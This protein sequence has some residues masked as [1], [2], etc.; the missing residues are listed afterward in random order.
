MLWC[1]LFGPCTDGQSAPQRHPNG[2][3]DYLS[4][5]HQS[6]KDPWHKGHPRIPRKY[7]DTSFNNQSAGAITQRCGTGYYRERTGPH[8]G[9]CV[10]CNC[11]SLS[12][13]CDEQTGRCLNC[14]YNTDGD[15]CER[16]KEGY[17]G[18]AA[19]KTC[20][21]CPCPFRANN[22]AVACLDIGANE[23]ECL[24]KPG[25]TG[26]RCERCAPDYYG[27]P[28]IYGGRCQRCHCDATS[29]CDHL[30]G[31][32][33]KPDDPGTN[34]QCIECDSCTQALL[35]DLEN[36]DDGLELLRQQL[37][38]IAYNSSP[39]NL[40]QLEGAI[41]E[42]KALVGRYSTIVDAQGPKVNLLEA[43]V[44][45]LDQDISLLEDKA[46]YTLSD[47]E[48]VL[49][50]VI[51]TKQRAEDFIPKAQDLLMNIEDL[52][53]QLSEANS[54]VNNITVGV[55]EVARMMKV[56]QRMV[57]EMRQLGCSNQTEKA[58]REQEGAHKRET[59][60]FWLSL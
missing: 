22:F 12:N 13:E 1:A 28:M 10:P 48:N 46:S 25:Y 29:T 45:S 57:K 20:R 2:R 42:T 5:N 14:Q 27:N 53:R 18:N 52:L 6:G 8:R 39:A 33:K 40:N 9:Q 59:G 26:T 19:Q 32:C 36:M 50:K 60:A 3:Y 58:A 51:Q 41:N 54:S 31:K 11:N 17:Y 55:E 15:R 43:E 47:A 56:V 23:I 34:D 24:C 21:G 35:N 44:M 4:Q 7:C 49:V 30:T 37:Q 38:G 16:C